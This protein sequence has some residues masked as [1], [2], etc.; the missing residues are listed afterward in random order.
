MN[1][2]ELRAP[3]PDDGMAIGRVLTSAAVAAWADWLGS[4]RIVD[5]NRDR[6][7]PADLVAVDDGAVCGFVAWDIAT[8]EVTRLY[9]DPRVWGQG[10]GRALLDAALETMARAGVKQAWLRTEERNDRACRF[11][12]SHGWRA[13]GEVLERDWHGAHLRELR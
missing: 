4:D 3:G 6:V 9:T 12:E 8:G 2:W 11:Y 13:T 7:H 5:A 1:S 10:V